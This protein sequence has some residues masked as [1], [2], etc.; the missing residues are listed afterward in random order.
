MT[1]A[2]MAMCPQLSVADVRSDGVDQTHLWAELS[3]GSV[4]VALTTP[5]AEREVAFNI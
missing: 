5:L 1:H 4:N 2:V 3:L